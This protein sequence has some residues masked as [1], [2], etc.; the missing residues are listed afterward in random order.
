MTELLLLFGLGV[1]G[2]LLVDPFFSGALTKSGVAKLEVLV[3]VVAPLLVHCLGRMHADPAL[4]RRSFGAVLRQ[5]WPALLL[6]LLITGG[7]LYAR[8]VREVRET[9]LNF[10]LGLL[11]LPL[12]A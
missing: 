4:W 6:G 2:L 7:S 10:G 12:M 3:L 9:F 5:W 1:S 8:E 11:F